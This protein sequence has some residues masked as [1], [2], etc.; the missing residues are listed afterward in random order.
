[1]RGKDNIESIKWISNY[2]EVIFNGLSLSLKIIF[3]YRFIEV[4]WNINIKFRILSVCIIICI[5][6]S[7]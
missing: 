3:Y 5:N 1:M 7:P 4:K 6:V 2:I